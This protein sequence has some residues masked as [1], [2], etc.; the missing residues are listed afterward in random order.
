MEGPNKAVAVAGGLQ[1]LCELLSHPAR[2]LV[3]LT[4]VEVLRENE[5]KKSNPEKK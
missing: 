2:A 3:E 5:K 4:G 1:R